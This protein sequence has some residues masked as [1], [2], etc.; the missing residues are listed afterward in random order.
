MV[1]G[2]HARARRKRYRQIA[3][4]LNEP[5]RARA[6]LSRWKPERLDVAVSV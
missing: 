6:A 5:N 2:A 3:P 1:R 4:V